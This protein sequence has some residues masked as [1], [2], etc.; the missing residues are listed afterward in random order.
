MYN[1]FLVQTIEAGRLASIQVVQRLKDIEPK[2]AE[3]Q[4]LIINFVYAAKYNLVQR[5]DEFYQ[6]LFVTKEGSLVGSIA[7]ENELLFQL[8]NQLESVDRECLGMLRAIVDN[9]MNVAGVGYTNCANSV[10]D[11]LDREL[12]RTHKL[13]ELAGLDIFYQRL[14]D[15]F[16]GENIFAGPERILAK[17]NSKSDEI[18]AVGIDYLSGFFDIVETFSSALW[19]LRNAYKMCLKTNE[20]ILNLTFEASQSQLTNICVGTLL[21]S[22]V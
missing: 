6:Q 7:L 20:S 4:R 15:A 9:N 1:L 19:R 21:N 16:E 3:I 12:Q 2:Y 10:Q 17:L 8:D 13:L 14:L 18:D 5:K 11:G 22:D